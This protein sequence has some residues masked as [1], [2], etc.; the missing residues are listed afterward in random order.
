MRGEH[1]WSSPPDENQILVDHGND[2]D[3]IWAFG[4]SPYNQTMVMNLWADL[5]ERPKTMSFA[6]HWGEKMV[7][8]H[9]YKPEKMVKFNRQWEMRLGLEDL[10]AKHIN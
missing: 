2:E 3:S 9:F 1:L 8:P 4:K 10:K 7:M 6:P 5:S